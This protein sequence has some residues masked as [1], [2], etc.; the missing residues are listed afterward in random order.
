MRQLILGKLNTCLL[1]FKAEKL[2]SNSR[3][4]NRTYEENTSKNTL[5]KTKNEEAI[6]LPF[7]SQRAISRDGFEVLLRMVVNLMRSDSENA[8]VVIIV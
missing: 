2:Q 5:Q 4:L 8:F 3:M 1:W 6:G 7:Y